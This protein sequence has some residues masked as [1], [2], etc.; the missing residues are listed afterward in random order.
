MKVTNR[1]FVQLSHTFD[2]QKHK[3]DGSYVSEKLDGMR[4]LW[5]PETRGLDFQTIP[6]AN[7]NKDD[8]AHKCSGL[9]SRYGKPI[10]AP[11][12]LL[13]QLPTHPLDGELYAGRGNHQLCMSAVKK[14]VPRV[15]EW[16]KIGYYVFDAPSWARI[17]E[18]GRINSPNFPNKIIEPYCGSKIGVDSTHRWW[19]V[20]RYESVLQFLT[21][22]YKELQVGSA[23]GTWGV[24]PQE[25]LPMFRSGAELRIH[26]LMD[27]VIALGGEGLILRRPH[28]TWQPRRTDESLKVKRMQ[29]A[30][31]TV[32]GYKF[33]VGKLLGLIGSFQLHAVVGGKVVVVEDELELL[34]V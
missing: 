10:F 7:T 9:W 11:D 24:L 6:F 18:P 14:H 13:D 5:L 22:H 20:R 16:S 30:E 32:I 4:A 3:A 26:Q 27:N 21:K 29:D 34:K 23:G 25:Q 2:P 33:G 31:G 19:Y 12:S 8:R 1:Q 28:A 17:L 15:D